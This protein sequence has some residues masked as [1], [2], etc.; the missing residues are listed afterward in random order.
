MKIKILV[1][2]VTK[3]SHSLLVGLIHTCGRYTKKTAYD[4]AT[5]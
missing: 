4:I 2:H 3:V 1:Y 5:W